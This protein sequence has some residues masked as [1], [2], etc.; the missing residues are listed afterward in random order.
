MRMKFH[1]MRLDHLAAN[2]Q[3]VRV[4]YSSGDISAARNPG[5][6]PAV[7]SAE[8]SWSEENGASR[9]FAVAEMRF[10]RCIKNVLI[11]CCR[12]LMSASLAAFLGIKSMRTI[13][14]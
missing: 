9:S 11:S 13:R 8:A 14:L 3:L 7:F 2:R 4:R 1:N 10:L 6:T 5:S 12:V